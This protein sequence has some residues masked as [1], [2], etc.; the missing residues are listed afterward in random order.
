MGHGCWDWRLSWLW[1]FVMLSSGT[2][3]NAVWYK[4]TDVSTEEIDF[5]FRILYL[6]DE[7]SRLHPHVGKFLADYTKPC[8]LVV[9]DISEEHRAFNF[10]VKQAKHSGRA[11]MYPVRKDEA[12]IYEACPVSKDTKVLNMYNN[13]NLQK[14]HWMNFLYITLFFNIVAGIVQIFIKSWN[15]RL[16]PRVIIVVELPSVNSR[17]HFVTFCRFITLP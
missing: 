9:T 16:Y 5:L 12:Y 4:C 14:R 10:R 6:E 15:Q 8:Q 2:W 13:F 3:P 17:H 11:E 7:S 1:L